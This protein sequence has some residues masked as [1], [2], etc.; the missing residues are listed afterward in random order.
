MT[1][2]PLQ[3]TEHETHISA[4]PDAVFAVL[5]DAPGWPAVFPPSVHVE[6]IERT[7]S[8]ERIRIWATANGSLRTWTS[9]REF[10][11]RA[12]RI[13]FRQE[14]SAHPVAAMGGEWTVEEA[15][16]GGT[17]VRLTHDFRAVDDD[18]ETI[19]WI[20][21]A[22]DRN[23]EAEL[24]SLRSALERPD[25][26]APTTFEDTVL[27]NGRAEDVY[28]FL[29]R[30]DLWPERLSHVARIAVKEEEPGLQH[31][32]M[33]TLAADGS[34]HTTA[35]VRVCSPERRVIVYKQ[36]RT[37]ALLSLHLGRWS[38]R[39]GGDGD[40]IAVT[41]AHTVSVIRSAVPGILGERATE[42]DAVDFVR[43]AL[44]RNSLLTLEAAKRYAESRA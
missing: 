11:E 32:E 4:P 21:R 43:R 25:G 3:E 26:T 22:V 28:E 23:S 13:R 33:D 7:G 16:D 34:T 44:G 5:A 35:S 39:P 14:V 17:R 1:E 18:P 24:A 38:V 6:Q 10:D 31:M 20:H 29:Y 36:L 27:V 2:S 12:R 8:G 40:G 19:G 41:S 42:T 9:R 15:G 30:S 37:P